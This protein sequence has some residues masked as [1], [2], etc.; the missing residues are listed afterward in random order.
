M[1]VLIVEHSSEGQAALGRRLDSIDR[2][3]KDTLDL[4]VSLANEAT[5]AD[6]LGQTDVV[7]FGPGLEESAP[8]LARKAKV[9]APTVEVL[10]FVSAKGYSGSLFRTA[11][12][13][14]ARKVLSE[15]APLLDIVQ[16]LMSIQ[17]EFRL[18]G[19]IRSGKIIAVVQAK[20]GIG[21]TSTCAALAEVSGSN[22][23]K[24]IL[25]DLDIE[26]RDLCRALVVEGNQPTLVRTWVEG[27]EELSRETL[28]KALMEVSNNVAVLP[29]PDLMGAAVDMVGRIE[30]IDLVQSIINLCRVTAENT[31]VDVGGRVGPAAGTILRSADAVVVMIDDSILGLSAARFFISTLLSVVRN[32]DSV[33][34]LC[35]GISVSKEEL[36]LRMD[37][38]NRF[39]DRAWVL[40]SIP[41]DSLASQWPGS[42][43][44]L[45][46]LGRRQTKQAFDSI[47]MLLD[48]IPE[49]E[50]VAPPKLLPWLQTETAT[51]H[52]PAPAQNES[53]L[54]PFKILWQ[55]VANSF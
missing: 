41:F 53:T 45:F 54:N 27:S 28:R 50:Q 40:P 31:I 43:R 52:I 14:G 30:S 46:S 55:R 22:G 13:R 11:I 48:M 33:Y 9:S 6:R 1:R 42:G 7:I 12:S 38:E 5:F 4:Q 21:V 16:E 23:H 25:W 49:K 26:T 19:R 34:F 35:S 37:R 24:T 29:P 51:K 15:K 3:D 18:R 39:G 32:V 44:T 2:I 36:R 20:G 47:A 17:E 8:L 10:I